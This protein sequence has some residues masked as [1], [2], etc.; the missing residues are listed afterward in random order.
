LL[1]ITPQV[2]YKLEGSGCYAPLLLALA[3]G[4]YTQPSAEIWGPSVQI[5]FPGQKNCI[6]FSPNKNCPIFMYFC[7]YKLLCIQ[8]CSKYFFWIDPVNLFSISVFFLVCLLTHFI[9]I[10]GENLLTKPIQ[11]LKKFQEL[12][13]V[14]SNQ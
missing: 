8:T 10:F 11:P 2:Y 14:D 4:C 9:F 6:F 1:Y 12:F 7:V 3:E 13:L 5:I